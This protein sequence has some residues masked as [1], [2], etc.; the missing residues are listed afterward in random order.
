MGAGGSREVVKEAGGDRSCREVEGEED[1][2]VDT[3]SS[4]DTGEKEVR[5]GKMDGEGWSGKGRI[6]VL[7][8]WWNLM[9]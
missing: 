4:P 8:V 9:S 2:M 6:K 5:F 1:R 3:N 7:R